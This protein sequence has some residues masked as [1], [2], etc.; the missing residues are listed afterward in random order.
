MLFRSAYVV[1]V[2]RAI[3][4][5]VTGPGAHAGKT[6]E[7]GGPEAISMLDL[8]RLIAG[9][10]GR[11]PA[12]VLVPDAVASA[13]A[14]FGGWAPGAPMTWDQWLMLQKDNVVSAGTKG[15]AAFGIDPTPI[16]AVA[17]DWLVQYR[18]HGRFN[19]VSKAA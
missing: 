16:V 7:L 5:A 4:N 1:D 18:R 11:D 12:F 8:N 10:I 19:I 17:P 13:M 2:A 3:A 14:R 15:F 9:M 6:Y